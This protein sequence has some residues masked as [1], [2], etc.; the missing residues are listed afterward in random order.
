MIDKI[1]N[2]SLSEVPNEVARHRSAPSKNTAGQQADASLQLTHNSLIEDAKQVQIQD[3]NAV[4]KAR[5][6]I[7]TGQLDTGENIRAAAE[8]MVQF[9]I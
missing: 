2:N 3:Q 6:L 1:N 5:E 8:A 4:A 7:D 9:G